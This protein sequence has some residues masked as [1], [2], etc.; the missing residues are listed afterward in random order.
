MQ[1]LLQFLI[2]MC[3]T[4]TPIEFHL[5]ISCAKFPLT[6]RSTFVWPSRNTDIFALLSVTLSLLLCRS[7]ILFSSRTCLLSA[8]VM[9]FHF[10]LA[11]STSCACQPAFIRNS[12]LYDLLFKQKLND[13][14]G[15]SWLKT[16]LQVRLESVCLPLCIIQIQIQGWLCC[17][18]CWRC[19]YWQHLHEAR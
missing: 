3:N 13:I 14:F 17:C 11:R 1:S 6:F 5:I 15:M 8:L 16:G 10:S 2:K 9:H 12:R 4:F 18:L 7:P 19:W